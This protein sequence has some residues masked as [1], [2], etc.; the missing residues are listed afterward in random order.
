MIT[1]NSFHEFGRFAL[2]FMVVDHGWEKVEST[3]GITRKTMS[4]GGAFIGGFIEPFAFMSD[5]FVNLVFCMGIGYLLSSTILL[6]N[7][8]KNA[9]ISIRYVF[10]RPIAGSLVG[11]CLFIPVLS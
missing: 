10:L 5:N 8:L 9:P 6:L 2:T 3:S 1:T 4:G 7:L 11:G